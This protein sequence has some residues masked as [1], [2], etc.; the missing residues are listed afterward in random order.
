M[1]SSRPRASARVEGPAVLNRVHLQTNWLVPLGGEV[2]P[3]RVAPFDERDF[4]LAPPALELFLATDGGVDPVKALEV[5]QPMYS[6][7]AGESA[8][9]S[10]AV[11]S[12]APPQTAGDAD[13]QNPRFAGENVNVIRTLVPLHTDSISRYVLRRCD[14]P[15]ACE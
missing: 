8:E 6:V 10:T 14:V 15:H 9:L 11:F 5:N 7:L 3:C 1:L 4:F 12:H 2:F 13:V